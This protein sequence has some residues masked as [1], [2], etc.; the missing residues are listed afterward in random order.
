[1]PFSIKSGVPQGSSLSPTLYSMYT[2]DIPL[3]SEGC[4]NIM[5]ADDITQIITYPGKSRMFMTRKTEREISK[6]NSYE[7][8]WKIKTN[9]TKF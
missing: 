1:M 9:A 4:F 6:I 8:K 2:S 3:L 7:T 5:Y